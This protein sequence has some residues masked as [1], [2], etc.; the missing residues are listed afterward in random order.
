MER[1]V[2]K[3]MTQI[4]ELRTLRHRL[5]SLE[6][7]LICLNIE[8]DELRTLDKK[9]MLKISENSKVEDFDLD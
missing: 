5:L 2:G 3:G 4:K 6:H 8:C 9:I 1:K 7:N